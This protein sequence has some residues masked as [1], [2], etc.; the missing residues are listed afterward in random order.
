M[1]RIRNHLPARSLFVSLISVI[2]ISSPLAYSGDRSEVINLHEDCTSNAISPLNLET[3]QALSHSV[4][5]LIRSHEIKDSPLIAQARVVER[6]SEFLQT[7]RQHQ[8][9]HISQV[10]KR[11]KINQAFAFFFQRDPESKQT[12]IERIASIFSNSIPSP[13]R[14]QRHFNQFLQKITERLF[15]QQAENPLHF[16]SHGVDHSLNV[17]DYIRDLYTKNPKITEAIKSKYE[18][19]ETEARLILETLGLSHDLGYPGVGMSEKPLHGPIGADYMRETQEDF[20]DFIHTQTAKKQTISE[21]MLTSVHNHSADK[22]D[23]RFPIKITTKDH[24]V[25]LAQLPDLKDVIVMRHL[26]VALIEHSALTEEETKEI[27]RIF[28][29]KP[30]VKYKQVETAFEG[31][32]AVFQLEHTQ[33]SSP[34]SAHSHPH[35]NSHFGLQYSEVDLL[36]NPLEASIRLC[37][38]MDI[39]PSRM[40]PLQRSP[41]FRAIYHLLGHGPDTQ[42][43]NQLEQSKNLVA[44]KILVDRVIESVLNRPEYSALSNFSKDE[45]RDSASRLR[46]VE[47]FHFGGTEAIQGISLRVSDGVPEII[48]LIDEAKY[49]ELNEIKMSEKNGHGQG[50]L[51]GVGAYQIWRAREALSTLR[52]DGKSLTLKVVSTIGKVLPF[53]TEPRK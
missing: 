44:R 53:N 30:E 7:Y 49:N 11:K 43:I 50:E 38:N 41:A 13:E 48:V 26:E 47:L 29:A 2:A 4:E 34:D 40:T 15:D 5:R 22:I 18:V 39:L 32:K 25:I 52:Y 14:D 35:S 19:S 3:F 12:P 9:Q 21:D 24:Q 17:V 37:D 45:I 31:R 33:G 46:P 36:K 20:L 42:A 27:R 16:V 1:T 23:E 10:S 51:I 8:L 6:I 28:E